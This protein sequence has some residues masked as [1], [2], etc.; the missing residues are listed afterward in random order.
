MSLDTVALTE[1]FNR[2]GVEISGMLTCT[3]FS[4]GQSNPTYLVKDSIGK[5][6][7]L[8]KKPDGLLISKTAHAVEREFRIQD[9][10][11]RNTDVPVPKMVFLCED[12]TIIGTPFYVME[13]VEGRIFVD[14]ALPEIPKEERW[15]YLQE[16]TR[17]LALIHSVKYKDIGLNGYGKDGGYYTRQ[18][19][20]LSRIHGDQASSIYKG[21]NKT[22]G[23]LPQFTKVSNW[24]KN[25]YC[26]DEI[27]IVHGDYKLDNVIFDKKL[28]K[29]IGVLDWEL[30]T[31]G[32][33]R[34]DLANMIQF[35]Q[36]PSTRRLI[37]GRPPSEID[38]SA[39][40]SELERIVQTYCKL[41]NHTYPLEGLFYA[42][43]FSFFRNSIIYHGI[44]ARSARGQAA[45]DHAKRV[46]ALGP[47][48]M[49]RAA[50]MIEEY[51]EKNVKTSHTSKL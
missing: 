21:T 1:Y 22:V 33:P 14:P 38:E 35:F 17:V 6:F 13:F 28:P 46:G 40:P 51:S 8:R 37:A 23:D 3:K 42:F 25:T 44:E 19:I 11:G 18:C 49:I 9:A 32:N 7:V 15:A 45:S 50:N 16:M 10:L 4:H 2:R 41:T 12:T 24:L 27:T 36:Y 39:D 20:S 29:I 47:P 31:I 30:S 34:A 43:I 48:T 5:K 26:P